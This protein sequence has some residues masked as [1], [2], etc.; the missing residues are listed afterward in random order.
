[1]KIN[2]IITCQ[3]YIILNFQ[4][5]S[6]YQ[7]NNTNSEESNANLFYGP[8]VALGAVSSG[9]I[10]YLCLAPLNK[11]FI[12]I[13]TFAIALGATYGLTYTHLLR[14]IL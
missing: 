2:I 4:D 5:Q 10:S 14:T 13:H 8:S 7:E 9:L 3:K 6:F 12:L 11:K 1:M